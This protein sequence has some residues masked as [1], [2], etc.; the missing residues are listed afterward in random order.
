MGA[1]A[2]KGAARRRRVPHVGLWEFPG[3]KAEG[4][5]TDDDALRRELREELGV[6][7]V[8]AV[9]VHVRDHEYPRAVVRVRFYVVHAWEGTPRGAEGQEVA[10]VRLGRMYRVPGLRWTGG[11]RWLLP[12]NRDAVRRVDE[13]ARDGMRE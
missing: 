13:A 7:V 2:Q 5:E 3:G 8:R 1:M 11:A 4:G 9:A 12:S 6:N 10:W